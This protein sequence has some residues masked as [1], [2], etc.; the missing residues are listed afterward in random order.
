[1]FGRS[2]LV[3]EAPPCH[4]DG[5]HWQWGLAHAR[6]R[7]HNEHRQ[8]D[9]DTQ[10]Q[11]YRHGGRCRTNLDGVV[12]VEASELVVIANIKRSRRPDHITSVTHSSRHGVE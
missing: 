2:A 4:L 8:T 5:A 9:T 12:S 10:T 7:V 3:E 1:M 11:T 6:R